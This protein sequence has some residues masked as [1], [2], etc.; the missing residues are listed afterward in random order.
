M[1]NLA[2]YSNYIYAAY[3]FSALVLV[4][5]MTFVLFQFFAKK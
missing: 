2:D 4:G 5:L 1:E 3:G